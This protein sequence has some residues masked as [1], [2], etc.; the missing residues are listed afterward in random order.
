MNRTA[1]IIINYFSDK[2]VSDLVNQFL[3]C[4]QSEQLS[5][6]IV[7]NG[8]SNLRFESSNVQ[9]LNADQNLGYFG[10]AQFALRYIKSKNLTFKYIIISNPDLSFG[11]TKFFSKLFGKE[12]PTNTGMVAPQIISG[13]NQQNCNPFMELRPNKYRIQFYK[14]IFSNYL[15]CLIY[16]ALGILKRKLLPGAPYSPKSEMHSI[17]AAHGAFMIFTE[18]YFSV[19]GNFMHDSFLYYEEIFVA[20]FCKKH[21][22]SIQYFSGLQVFHRERGSSGF[23]HSKKT[24][25]FMKE[26][27]RICAEKYF[28]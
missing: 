4:E 11:D 28:S 3:I 15:S 22:L 24:A 25:D 9:I 21:E 18:K 26:S 19:G 10:A 2:D 5:I 7:N 20:E 23:F 14:F 6:F 8:S 12:F 13:L 1:I 27:S 16:Q 17:Y